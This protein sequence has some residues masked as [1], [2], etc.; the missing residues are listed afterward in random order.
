MES[1][2]SQLDICN[3]VNNKLLIWGNYHPTTVT[4]QVI[5]DTTLAAIEAK[6]VPEPSTELGTLLAV[7]TFG[8]VGVLK[9]QQKRSALTTAGLVSSAQSSHTVD[10]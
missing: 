1:C 10:K 9:R 8:T 7:G 5:A 3:P 6:S 2:R 4:H